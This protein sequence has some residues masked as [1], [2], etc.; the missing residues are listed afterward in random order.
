MPVYDGI[1]YE[2]V[3]LPTREVLDAVP[4]DRNPAKQQKR[5]AHKLPFYT[6][7]DGATLVQ[8]PRHHRRRWTDAQWLA[9]REHTAAASAP[10]PTRA[11]RLTMLIRDHHEQSK[12]ARQL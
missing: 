8:Q 1:D 12:P 6:G 4:T 3:S 11:D 5:V 10:A 2:R 7:H 9:Y